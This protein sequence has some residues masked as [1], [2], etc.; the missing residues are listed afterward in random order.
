MRGATKLAIG[1]LA[2]SFSTVSL[3]RKDSV[4]SIPGE[5]II[6]LKSGVKKSVL[7]LKRFSFIQT[8]HPLNVSFGELYK[9]K[10]DQKASRESILNILRND[11]AVEYVEPNYIYKAI[12][13]YDAPAD[14]KFSSLWGLHNTGNNEPSST[15]K[16]LTGIVGADIDAINAWNQGIGSKEIKIAVID[17]GIDY[18]HPDLKNNMAVN[19]SEKNGKPGVDDDNNG[20]IDDIYGYDFAN[21]D[22]DP[23]DGHSHGTHCAGTIGAVHND[24]GV[25]GV[26]KEVSLVAVKFLS[27][28]GS[29]STESAVKAI[30]YATKRGVQIMSNSWGGGGFSQ[31]LEDAIKNANAKGIIF[32]AAAGNDSANNDNTPHYPSNYSVSNVISVAAHQITDSLASFSCYGRRTVHIAAPGK[33]ILSTIKNGGYAVYS[34]TSMATPHVSGAVGLLLAQERSLTPSEV[35]E[36]VMATSV[37]VAA[38]K[39]K[40][41]SGGRLNAYNM[42]TD[43]RPIRNEP[44]PSLWVRTNLQSAF[45]SEHPYKEGANFSKSFSVAGAKFLRVV[46]EKF[47]TEAGYD[48]LNVANGSGAVSEQISGTGTNYVSEYVEG[49]VINL[50]FKSDSSVNKWGFVIKQID[51]IK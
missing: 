8:Q 47:E 1:L 33:N 3:A 44:D 16:S 7:N 10:V 25:A 6:K 29:G 36:R 4:E 19:D 31:A 26:M 39:S 38:Y 15:V 40:T 48:V 50:N 22:A 20:F 2:I 24:V 9:V 49:D 18:N 21:N 14:P 34:G 28:S 51:Y 27:D 32:V 30:D 37:P 43:T 12:G 11:P 46:V 17:T 42:L 35:K 5:F 13:T 41:I 23:M 45:E